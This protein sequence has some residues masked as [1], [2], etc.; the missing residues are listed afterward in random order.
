LTVDEIS[1]NTAVANVLFHNQI[2][3][4]LC[5]NLVVFLQNLSKGVKSMD[6]ANIV[7]FA[8]F[9]IFDKSKEFP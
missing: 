2:S 6:F 3:R 8:D 5:L 9:V 4:T 1:E 7:K